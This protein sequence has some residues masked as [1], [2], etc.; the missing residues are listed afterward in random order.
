MAL[1]IYFCLIPAVTITQFLWRKE[2]G[3]TKLLLTKPLRII[4]QGVN[5]KFLAAVVLILVAVPLLY[6]LRQ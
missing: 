4:W 5:G 2:R 3:Y 6:M 1:D